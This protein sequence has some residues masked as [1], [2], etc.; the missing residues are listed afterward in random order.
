MLNN[1]AFIATKEV[2][3]GRVYYTLPRQG[4]MD[5]LLLCLTCVSTSA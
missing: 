1:I 3:P 5:L 2:C 4:V